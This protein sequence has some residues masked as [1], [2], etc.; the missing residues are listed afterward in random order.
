MANAFET[1]VARWAR[2]SGLHQVP[3][4]AAV[5]VPA[6]LGTAEVLVH[7][8]SSLRPT[9]SGERALVFRADRPSRATATVE[10]QRPKSAVRTP[11]TIVV[12]SGAPTDLATARCPGRSPDPKTRRPKPVNP[13]RV[14][15][16]MPTEPRR[17]ASSDPARRMLTSR[18]GGDSAVPRANKSAEGSLPVR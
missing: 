10:K 13:A 16:T 17:W 18:S 1:P 3:S 9:P 7:A 14:A 2:L 12:D 5:P 15:P 11:R 8:R 4:G 6:A